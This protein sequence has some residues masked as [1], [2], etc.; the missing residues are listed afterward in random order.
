MEILDLVQLRE[1]ADHYPWQLSGG[2]QQRVSIARALAF[3]PRLLLMD[4][5][6]GALDEMTRER[7]QIELMRLWRDTGIT[8]VFV[9]HS[10]TEAVFLSTRIAVMSP[11]PWSNRRR[12]R[13][14][15]APA[16]RG[17][18]PS[19][20]GVLPRGAPRPRGAAQRPRRRG[21][22][23]NWR[24]ML[25]RAWAPAVVAVVIIGGWELAVHVFD[26]QPL[27]LPAPS[28]I[29]QAFR[30]DW[31]AIASASRRTLA[32]VVLGLI[33]GVIAGV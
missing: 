21:A 24:R 17:R 13:R 1:F 11:R 18:D 8:V 14:R 7:L 6:L 31:T 29:V 33:V 25:R 2:M 19:Q 20:R 27:I 32:E 10:V 16:A 3:R 28:D 23:V 9:T 5:P 12:P 15:S 30:D 4:E 26:I 22:R